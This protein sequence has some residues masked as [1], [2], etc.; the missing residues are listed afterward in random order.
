MAAP[1]P[2]QQ[3]EANRHQVVQ[4]R[5]HEA[6]EA[7]VP[8]RGHSERRDGR[9]DDEGAP[10]SG[11]RRP[12]NPTRAGARERPGPAET[13]LERGGRE[14]GREGRLQRPEREQQR[15]ADA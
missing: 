1:P 12:G 7:R 2:E 3:P 10:P 4:V 13:D 11:N 15:A 14:P 5:E 6:S 9:R 8:E